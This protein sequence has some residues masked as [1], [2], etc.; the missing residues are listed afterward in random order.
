MIR[1][2]AFAAGLAVLSSAAMAD[3]FPGMNINHSGYT[4]Y[5]A[6][7]TEI[8][9]H[10]A[11]RGSHSWYADMETGPNGYVA[12][13]PT[14]LEVDGQTEVAG[15]ADYFSAATSNI[16][17]EQF[18]FVGGVDVVGG[19]MFFDFFDVTGAY[20]DGFGVQ[21][22]SAGNFIWT[23]TLGTPMNIAS[24]GY[25]QASVDDEDL[26]GVGSFAASQWFL[27]NNGATI[28]DAGAPEASPDFNYNFEIIGVAVP[29]PGSLALL[30]LGGLATVRRRR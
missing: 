25:V 16:S 17:M 20:V 15:V 9:N 19:V 12:F 11:D 29:T 10:S 24:G 26:A 30:G 5:Q 27:G 13:P 3:M 18:K 7:S 2:I 21:L 1:R 28:G 6:V 14:A 23:I 22:S 8:G 4:I